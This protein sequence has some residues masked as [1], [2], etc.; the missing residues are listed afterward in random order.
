MTSA[1][2]LGQ[3]A[4]N[5]ICCCWGDSSIQNLEFGDTGLYWISLIGFK[6][7]AFVE[8]LGK[9][10]GLRRNVTELEPTQRHHPKS[11]MLC[12]GDNETPDLGPVLSHSG[13]PS[14]G[15]RNKLEVLSGLDRKSVV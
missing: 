5:D 7:A 2:A 11:F 9:R 14:R 13:Q 1:Q 15:N 12:H 4:L 6:E 10:R 3:A 8:A